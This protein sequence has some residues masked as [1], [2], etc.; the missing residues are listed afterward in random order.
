LVIYSGL[1]GSPAVNNASMQLGR[2]PKH[3]NYLYWCKANEANGLGIEA[4][5]SH[6][7]AVLSNSSHLFLPKMRVKPTE[8]Q[9]LYFQVLVLVRQWKC[10]AIY[11]IFVPGLT[12][13]LSRLSLENLENLSIG[14]N[15]WKN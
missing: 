14:S 3:E 6:W 15:F 2:E 11:I 10:E 13:F 12:W 4:K 7:L 5:K 9:H 8:K 1:K